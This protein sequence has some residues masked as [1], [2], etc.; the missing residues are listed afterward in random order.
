MAT[1]EEIQAELDAANAK[2]A[3]LTTTITELDEQLK[4]A[5]EANAPTLDMDDMNIKEVAGALIQKIEDV[6]HNWG[7]RP[8]D[9][10]QMI[11]AIRDFM[12]TQHPM[13]ENNEKP[14]PKKE[15]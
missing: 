3:E 14:K 10:P 8:G 4:S 12:A 13:I 11:R 1:K 15:K 6:C 9:M 5:V 7:I 2:V